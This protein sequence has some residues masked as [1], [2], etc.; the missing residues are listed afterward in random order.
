MTR[1]DIIQKCRQNDRLAQK[2]L[3]ELTAPK[4]FLVCKRY[5]RQDA[6]IQAALTEAFYILFTKIYQLESMAA[7]DA[8]SKTITVNVCLQN[9]RK[10]KKFLS[11]KDEISESN[12]GTDVS[13]LDD[14]QE[15]DLLQLLEYLPSGAKAVFNLYVIEGYAHKEIAQLLDISEGTSKSQL[16][17]AKSKLRNLVEQYY[18]AKQN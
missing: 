14:L 8:W 10:S 17:Y 16:N 15:K 12:G 11:E 5:L 6:D 18:Y 13:V 1:E 9:I 7:F 3:Y 2:R 4:L